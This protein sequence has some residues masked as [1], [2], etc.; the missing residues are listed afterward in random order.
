MVCLPWDKSSV[1]ANTAAVWFIE[2]QNGQAQDNVDKKRGGI[3]G[4]EFTCPLGLK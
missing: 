3:S 2:Q 4:F 1:L